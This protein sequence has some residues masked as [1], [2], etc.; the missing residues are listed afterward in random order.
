MVGRNINDGHVKGYLD[1]TDSWKDMMKTQ[2]THTFV[3]YQY[4]LHLR[5]RNSYGWE[6]VP[7]IM[8]RC[9]TVTLDF[10]AKQ[11]SVVGG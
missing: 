3:E 2:G 9:S 11:V 8:E 4:T 10:K 5:A 6:I 7:S 1:L